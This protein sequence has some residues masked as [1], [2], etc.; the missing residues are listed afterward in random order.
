MGLID[1]HKQGTGREA[2]FYVRPTTSPTPRWEWALTDNWGKDRPNIRLEYG[3]LLN[4]FRVVALGDFGTR[5]LGVGSKR[6]R[7]QGLPG[8][9]PRAG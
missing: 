5:V 2:R 4:D 6:G 9:G 7:G 3:G 1:S 8:H